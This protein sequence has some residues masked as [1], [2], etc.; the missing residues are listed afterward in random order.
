MKKRLDNKE[1]YELIAKYN[2][3]LADPA[4]VKMIEKLIEGGVIHLTELHELNQLNEQ[5]MSI[6][7]P[8]PTMRVDDQF[9]KVL[10]EEKK[11]LNHVKHSFKMPDW[12][13]LFPRLAFAMVVLLIGFATGYLTKAPSQDTDVHALTQE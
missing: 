1:V 9:Y 2:E 3:G 11:K 13:I 12:N 8:S 7:D 5:I 10:A 6:N 4:E